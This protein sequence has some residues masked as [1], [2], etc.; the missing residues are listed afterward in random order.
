MESLDHVFGQGNVLGGLCRI[1]A[2]LEPDNI[3][4]H[5]GFDPILVI[6][7]RNQKGKDIVDSFKTIAGNANFDFQVSNRIE[8]AMWEKFFSLATF[9]GVTCIMRSPIGCVASSV[10]G[11]AFIA[12]VYSEAAAVAHAYGFTPT[13]VAY[14]TDLK[15]LTDPTSE[16]TASM[17]RDLESGNPIEADHIIGDL[18]LRG[19]AAGLPMKLFKI[20][21]IHMEAT[22]LRLEKKKASAEST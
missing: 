10:E 15:Q 19:R 3:I 14:D 13:P 16:L 11:R 12:D 2:I 7:A 17:L 5:L 4:H 1:A 21:W 18:Y 22:L 6:G 20:I 8:H 9:S